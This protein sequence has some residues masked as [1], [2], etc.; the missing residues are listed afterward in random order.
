MPSHLH[1]T[2]VEMFRDRPA[3]AAE[4]LAGPLG[5]SVAGASSGPAC[6]Q[7]ISARHGDQLL[8]TQLFADGESATHTESSQ[9]TPS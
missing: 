1:E 3:L 2:L 7:A 8:G 4:L 6:P 9:K 5:V